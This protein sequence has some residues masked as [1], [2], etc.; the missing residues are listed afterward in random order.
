M[1]GRPRSLIRSISPGLVAGASDNDPTT[2]GTLAV[3]GATTAFALSWLVVLLLPMLIVI[4]VISAQVG[5]MTG[6]GLQEVVAR[7]SR[8]T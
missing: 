1:N 4:Q 2:V 6:V 7:R 3:V 5:V 8:R